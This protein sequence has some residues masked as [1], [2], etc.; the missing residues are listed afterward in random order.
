MFATIPGGLETIAGRYPIS[1]WINCGKLGERQKQREVA[2]TWIIGYMSKQLQKFFGW[3]SEGVQIPVFWIW[4]RNSIWKDVEW[5]SPELRESSRLS[6][7]SIWFPVND[8]D[9][10]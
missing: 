2:W 4:E 7:G 3:S 5:M 9:W 10:Y 8:I 1:G 6:L